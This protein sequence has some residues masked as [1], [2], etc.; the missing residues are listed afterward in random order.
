MDS[1]VFRRVIRKLDRFSEA[2][3]EALLNFSEMD[4]STASK[5]F[6]QRMFGWLSDDKRDI[7][8]LLV[9]PETNDNTSKHDLLARLAYCYSF[10]PEKKFQDLLL[11][12]HQKIGVFISDKHVRVHIAKWETSLL[13]GF[14]RWVIV[15]AHKPSG[16]AQSVLQLETS[17]SKKWL[18]ADDAEEYVVP[19]SEG[20]M[21]L[22]LIRLKN[23][24]KLMDLWGKRVVADEGEEKLVKSCQCSKPDFGESLTIGLFVLAW[25]VA[26]RYED[27]WMD[28]QGYA[29]PDVPELD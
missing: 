13:R 2:L 15:E 19:E 17:V 9:R 18:S 11:A 29:I 26:G 28:A 3:D 4:D 10:G 25:K 8:A 5:E 27:K 24:P 14:L 7:G 1:A 12:N 6:K 23:L 22:V 20:D 16:D 21:K